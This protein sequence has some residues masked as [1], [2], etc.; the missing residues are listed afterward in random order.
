MNK[1]N[2]GR[3]IANARRN[4]GLTQQDLATRL[5]VT[6]TAVSKWERG[7]CYPDITILEKL[8]QALGLTLSQLLSSE[9]NSDIAQTE[10]GMTSLLDIAKESSHKQKAKIWRSILFTALSVALLFCL[11]YVCFTFTKVHVISARYI[12]CQTK[13]EQTFVYMERKDDL[14][15]LLCEDP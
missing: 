7:L 14:L 6:N 3:Y 9:S 8:A 4:A 11:V 15:C 13:G 2:F 10:E 5:N 1:E 12:G